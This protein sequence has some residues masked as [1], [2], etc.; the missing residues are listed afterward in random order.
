MYEK[1]L[2]YLFNSFDV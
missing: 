1:I 2:N